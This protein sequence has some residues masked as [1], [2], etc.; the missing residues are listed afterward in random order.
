M[1]P[2]HGSITYDNI[3]GIFAGIFAGI[4]VVL[5]MEC[6]LINSKSSVDNK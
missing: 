1:I 4:S 3:F 5:F 2:A 6:C